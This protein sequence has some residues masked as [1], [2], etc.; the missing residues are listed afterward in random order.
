MLLPLT[1]IVAVEINILQK[2]TEFVTVLNPS[3]Y[4]LSS[5]IVLF[6]LPFNF[7]SLSVNI[8]MLGRLLTFLQDKTICGIA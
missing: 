2:G 7:R 6:K 1:Y 4:F 5:T 8:I 3:A